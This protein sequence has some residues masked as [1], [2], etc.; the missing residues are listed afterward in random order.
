MIRDAF[1]IEEL[2]PIDFEAIELIESEIDRRRALWHYF[3]PDVFVPGKYDR[4]ADLIDGAIY[5]LESLEGRGQFWTSPILSAWIKRA[6]FT[7]KFRPKD[8][9]YGPY[10]YEVYHPV[11]SVLGNISNPGTFLPKL[12]RYIRTFKDRK[13]KLD[14][15]DYS[16]I[17]FSIFNSTP[18]TPIDWKILKVAQVLIEEI[19]KPLLDGFELSSFIKQQQFEFAKKLTL[20]KRV[21][22]QFYKSGFRVSITNERSVF[23]LSRYILQFP[24]PYHYEV[25]FKNVMLQQ[26]FLT[27]GRY[28]LQEITMNFPTENFDW[29]VLTEKIH[30]EFQIYRTTLFREKISRRNFLTYFDVPSQDWIIPWDTLV[31]EWKEFLDE[32]LDK[33]PTEPDWGVI[34]PDEEILQ[35]IDLI[36]EDPLCMNSDLQVKTKIPLEKIKAIRKVLEEE[37]LAYRALVFFNS[38]LCDSCIIDIPGVETWKYRLL[39]KISEIFPS[40]IIFME[41]LRTSEKSLRA[42]YIH[43]PTH[44]NTFIKLFQK[45]FQGIFDFKLHQ[46][47]WRARFRIPAHQTFDPKTGTW[48][49]NP[50]DYSIHPMPFAKLKRGI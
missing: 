30:Q 50:A 37:V 38:D 17:F 34:M 6:G 48:N 20:Q 24:F 21:A 10:G 2:E 41:N 28:N 32:D 27:G 8:I 25:S 40:W 36:E 5:Y 23:G 14:I 42:G 33:T 44:I 13:L 47:Y 43:K 1:Q 39:A 7:R 9:E 11:W 22:A 12:I 4:R 49:F 31:Q 35:I 15:N 19:Q 18:P 26:N 45:I 16:F 29:K 3:I 46:M